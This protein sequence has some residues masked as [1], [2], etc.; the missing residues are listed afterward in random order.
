MGLFDWLRGGSADEV[1]CPE[2]HLESYKRLGEQVFGLHV[3]ISESR[4][5][6]ALAYLNAARSL[7]TMS[8]ALLGDALTSGKKKPVPI[9]SHEQADDW[10]GQIPDLLVAARQEAAFEHSA[11][12]P[13]PVRIGVQIEGPSPCPIEHLAGLRR[14]A[15]E[16]EALVTDGIAQARLEG[17]RFK[18]AILLYEEARTRK[19]AADAIV[20]IITNG[21]HVSEESHED[22]E[23]QYWMALSNYILVAQGMKAADVLGPEDLKKPQAPK[24]PAPKPNPIPTQETRR[25]KLDSNDIW[26][27]TSQSAIRDIKRSGEWEQA[28][29]DLIEHW[30]THH[31]REE[32]RTY[33]YTVE[34]LLRTGHIVEESYWYCCPFPTVYRVGSKPVRILGYEIPRGYVFVYEYG[35]DGAPG[36]FIYQP[37]FSKADSRKYC[38]D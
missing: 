16:M 26:K 7:Q 23:A 25:C 34:Q 9:V 18:F 1:V 5:S 20:G 22:A 11:S 8:D 35:D 30:G 12:V 37:S 29:H 15:A 13:L 6:R 21:R 24:E 4:H 38:E 31:I 10:Y 2:E 32:E 36:R 17:D 19:Q 3:E 14:A 33:E 27:V 28:E